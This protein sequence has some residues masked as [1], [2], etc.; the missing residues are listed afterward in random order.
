M[1]QDTTD[2]SCVTPPTVIWIMDLDKEAHTGMQ[3]KNAPVIL[4]KPCKINSKIYIQLFLRNFLY[5]N[6]KFPKNVQNNPTE[7]FSL[8]YSYFDNCLAKLASSETKIQ[9]SSYL[10]TSPNSWLNN[11]SK[12]E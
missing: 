3:E 11:F 12:Y 9:M 8:L 1:A 10:K 2:A 4:L 6:K 7:K 5:L